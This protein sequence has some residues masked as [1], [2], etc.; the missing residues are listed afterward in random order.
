[1]SRLLDGVTP[2]LHEMLAEGASLVPSLDAGGGLVR[3]RCGELANV[4]VGSYQRSG[5]S[6]KTPVVNPPLVRWGY[7]SITK[8]LVGVVMQMLM[9]NESLPH[10]SWSLPLEKN[11]TVSRIFCAVTMT[12]MMVKQ[13]QKN[14]FRV[15]SHKQFWWIFQTK[16]QV[17]NDKLLQW[18]PLAVGTAYEN[19]SLLDVAS[20]TACLIPDG[21]PISE[22]TMQEIYQQ[23]YL[24]GYPAGRAVW[25]NNTLQ[26][27]P[28]SNCIPELNTQTNYVHVDGV[29]ILALIEETITGVDF[30]TLTKSL[31]FDPLGMSS[32][33]VQYANPAGGLWATLGDV[34]LYG[35]WLVD[36][37]KNHP[38][39]IAKSVLKHQDF[40]D[41][42]SPIKKRLGS[43]NVV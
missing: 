24:G 43:A 36:G 31:I 2:F 22:A 8:T 10:I 7:A 13:H 14:I 19:A 38:D 1:M 33:E 4:A 5:A 6:S 9:A 26:Y 20:H 3:N 21:A 41:L 23:N 11:E 37:Y 18:L 28:L 27:P 12:L 32:A 39:A 16:K 15:C 35:Q 29:Q 25:V 34:G 42:M 40:V 30:G 17:R